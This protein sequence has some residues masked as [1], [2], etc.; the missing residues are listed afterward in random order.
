[1]TADYMQYLDQDAIEIYTDHDMYGHPNAGTD[2]PELTVATDEL[3]QLG[4]ETVV[5]DYSRRGGMSSY[6]DFHL[7]PSGVPILLAMC[8]SILNN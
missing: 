7:N 5:L 8:S 1:M 4:I 3:A 6:A 2:L